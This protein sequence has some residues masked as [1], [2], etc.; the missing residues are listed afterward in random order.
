MRI[1]LIRHGETDHN[2]AKRIQGPLIDD[3]L[4]A[5]GRQQSEALEARYLAERARGAR[6]AAVYASPLK[7]AWE[8]AEA[9][10][11]AMGLPRVEPMPAM[12]EFSWG[13]YLG[14]VE[15][16]DV[17]AK[18]REIHERWRRGDLAHAP[19]EGESPLS[20]WRRA[21]EGL[22]P[23]FERHKGEE[24]AVVAHGRINKIA[25]ARMVRGDLSRM[26][27]FPQ[28][29]TAVT[30]LEHDDDAPF[31]DAWRLIVLNDTS[32]LRG[33][34]RAGGTAAEGEPPLV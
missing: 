27:E 6:L 30:I 18:M 24:I 7:R 14:K 16:P 15:T 29:N 2:V 26:E 34:G 19:P 23:A 17:V 28:G 10:A 3:P 20:A 13:I 9:V 11:R 5:R 4:N 8:T 21:R 12:V 25:L 22:A 33:V 1:H 32:H 31:D